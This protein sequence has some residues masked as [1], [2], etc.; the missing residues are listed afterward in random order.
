MLDYTLSHIQKVH[1]L[2]EEALQNVYILFYTQ[3]DFISNNTD[4]FWCAFLFYVK[5]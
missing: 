3:I 5:D 1:S 4:T 2:N